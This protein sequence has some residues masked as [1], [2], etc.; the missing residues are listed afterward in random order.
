MILQQYI[1]E[2]LFRQRVCVIPQLGTFTLQHFPAQY[3]VNS[4][5]L[6]PPWDQVLFSQTYQDD[7]SCVEWIALKENLVP[8]VAQRKLDKYLEEI[9]AELRTGKPMELPGIGTLQGD[10]AGNIHFFAEKLPVTQESLDLFPIREEEEEVTTSAPA[11]VEPIEPVMTEEVEN[12]LE[13]IE[14]ESSFKWWWAVAALA[15]VAA[16]AGAWWYINQ[17][18]HHA[19][20][21]TD[22]PMDSVIQDTPAVQTAPVDSM[23]VDS[24]AAMP[25]VD[26][27]KYVAVYMTTK[28]SAV[29]AKELKSQLG[30]RRKVIMYQKDSAYHLAV[31]IDNADTIAALEK[32]RQEFG[33]FRPIHLEK[34]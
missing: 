31:E 10:F 13:A 21:T 1:Q 6:T 2:V 11:P 19:N 14:E 28:D 34:H 4:Q 3:N 5:T 15:V 23:S 30:W 27:S 20:T 12:V 18:S 16:A 25:I 9:K 8:S 32:V 7:G 24:S 33:K 29:A 17:Q 22:I 26:T